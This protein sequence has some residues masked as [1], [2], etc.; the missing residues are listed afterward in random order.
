MRCDPSS[1]LL[2]EEPWTFLPPANWPQNIQPCG[3]WRRRAKNSGSSV[4]W[5]VIHCFHM[6]S[7]VAYTSSEKI[8][9]LPIFWPGRVL[10]C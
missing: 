4:L 6:K 8:T 2:L 10:S 1:F 9:S 3:F 7:V 5:I